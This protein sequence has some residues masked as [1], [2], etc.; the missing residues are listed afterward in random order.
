MFRKNYQHLQMPLFSSID[1]LPEKQL[2]RLDGSWA[3]TFY[4]EV[5]VHIDEDLFAVLY[6]DEP[7]RPNIPINV[8]TGL[9]MLKSGFGW[10]DEEMYDA[11]CY[12]VQVRYA[13][14]YRELGEGHFELRTVYNFRQRLSRHMQETG[15]NLIDQ[16]FEQVTDEQISAFQ[17]KTGKLRMDSTQIASNIR[18]M[19][20]LQLLVE[21]VQRVHRMLSE[22]DQARYTADFASYLSGSSGQYL[23]RLKGEETADHLQRIGQL[24]SRLV[25]NLADAYADDPVYQML[26]RVFSDHFSVEAAGLRPKQGQELGAGSLQSADDLEAT[27]RQK[28]GT[29]YKGYVVNV[30]ETCDPDNDLQLVVKV[31]TAPNTTDDAI[32]LEEALPSLKART[33]VD[34]MHTDGGYNSETVDKKMR[35]QGVD[36]VQTAIR[37][38]APAA[39]RLGLADFEIETTDQ[40]QPV[41]VTCP[42]GQ[43]ATVESGRKPHRYLARLDTTQCA[44]CAWRDRCRIQVGKRDPRPVLRFSQREVE[45]ARRRRRSA[46][47]RASGSNLRAAVEATV[48]SLKR[49]FGND[50]LPVRGQFRVSVMMIGAA[51]MANVRRIQRYTVSKDMGNGRNLAPQEPQSSQAMLAAFPFSSLFSRFCRSLSHFFARQYSLAASF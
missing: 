32:L 38:G 21:V 24:M 9:E 18:E 13:F 22:A 4:R 8:L 25:N 29:G 20:R 2:K 42:Q 15:E 31:Q 46:Q 17:L 12:N 27:Y 1:S 51:L 37:G 30:T 3:G 47:A 6:S 16:C 11:F 48:A 23:Y 40:G 36:H 14:G 39:D 49:P 28:R 35:E 50:K 43:T 44:G 19:A 41:S 7:S 10:S 33:D 26:K 5:F 45:V 34:E